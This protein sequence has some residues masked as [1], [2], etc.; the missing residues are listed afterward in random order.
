MMENID[1]LIDRKAGD[2]SLTITDD[3]GVDGE[4]TL[5]VEQAWA[6]VCKL[7]DAMR[8]LNNEA[9]EKAIGDGKRVQIERRR[10]EPSYTVSIDTRGA[11]NPEQVQAAVL[12]SI[13]ADSKRPRHMPPGFPAAIKK[14]GLRNWVEP[15]DAP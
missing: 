9:I 14:S 4:V 10:S 2:M 3:S 11:H 5:S 6:L 15:V 12:E 8:Q 13:G 7:M 1:I